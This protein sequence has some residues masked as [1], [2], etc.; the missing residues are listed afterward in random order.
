MSVNGVCFAKSRNSCSRKTTLGPPGVSDATK[1]VFNGC[2]VSK[3]Y[4][5][6]SRR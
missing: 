3:L 5:V 4:G 6:W 2:I 1:L